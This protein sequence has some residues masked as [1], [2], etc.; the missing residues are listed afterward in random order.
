MFTGASPRH[1]PSN[2]TISVSDHLTMLANSVNETARM[3]RVILSLLLIAALYLSLTLL[4][5]SDDNLLRN[6]HVRLPQL[7]TG[8]ALDTSYIFAPIV[9][10]YL[11]LQ[12]LF[13]F[14]ILTRKVRT[15]QAALHSPPSL[16][17]NRNNSHYHEWLSPI[18]FVQMFQKAGRTSDVAKALSI[19]AIILV[20][21]T[22]LFLVDLSFMRYQS[23]SISALHH[24]CFSIDLIAVSL[25]TLY[26][27]KNAQQITGKST[28]GKD[29][30]AG[31]W[32]KVVRRAQQ[33][34][35]ILRLIVGMAAVAVALIMLWV[36]SWP[37]AYNAATKIDEN[38][39]RRVF[40]SFS[41][42]DD[43][44]C[45]ELPWR[46]GCR[47]LDLTGSTLTRL[48]GDVSEVEPLGDLDGKEVALYQ[49]RYGVD[50]RGRSLRY[51]NFR[52]AWIPGA[53]FDEADLRGAN[54]YLAYGEGSSLRQ[55][56]LSGA[57]F[58]FAQFNNADFGGA[59][60][61]G[62]EARRSK[63]NAANF[64]GASVLGANLANAELN[65]A[66]LGNAD[67]TGSI[68][69][70]AELNGAWISSLVL[71]NAKLPGASI[72]AAEG[73]PAKTEDA[74]VENV[75]WRIADLRQA[76][77]LLGRVECKDGKNIV[78]C[79]MWNFPRD[80]GLAWIKRVS[81]ADILQSWSEEET[82]MPSWIDEPLAK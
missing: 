65:G 7:E 32:A 23:S 55:A 29:S 27:N 80:F 18:S 25:F 38:D 74:V 53:R 46:G 24:I 22:L 48:G 76:T 77:P 62:I 73:L 39:W 33:V 34:A 40:A 51:A 13:L 28:E 81:L 61:R 17:N 44:L 58:S 31:C 2:P 8:I 63:L 30:L 69:R 47:N 50:L 64:S 45:E 35:R 1:T 14:A 75:K 9:F 6:S 43:F 5:S 3:A 78:G 12:T 11:H 20:P 15:F 68:L 10:V 41:L 70:E 59:V 16:S 42:Y 71:A 26:T 36:Y 56:D 82:D 67:M 66:D 72:I 21:L 19:F 52:E 49:R 54:F 57:T 4:S 37:P 60:L 79:Y